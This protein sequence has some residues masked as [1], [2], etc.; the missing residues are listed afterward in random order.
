MPKPLS[1]ECGECRACRRR[2]RYAA[3][4]LEAKLEFRARA[5]ERNRAW[6][7]KN[8][9][10]HR[11]KKQRVRDPVQKRAWNVIA[12]RR[13]RGKLHPQPCEVCGAAPAQVHHDDY[14]KPLEVR[15]LCL[16]HHLEHHQRER[17]AREMEVLT[18][19][20]GGVG[21]LAVIGRCP[22]PSEDPGEPERR[23]DNTGRRP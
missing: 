2:A 5:A 15:W 7:A 4:S 8:P 18:Q 19:V 23:R 1:C 21:E 12:N 17:L 13:R 10:D 11:Q 6:R 9:G 20:R 14:T 22:L 16:P 3:L